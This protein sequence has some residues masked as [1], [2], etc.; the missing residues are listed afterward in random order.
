M[1]TDT[2]V[3][4]NKMPFMAAIPGLPLS[5]LAKRLVG[6]IRNGTGPKGVKGIVQALVY[7]DENGQPILVV[8]GPSFNVETGEVS[9]PEFVKETAREVVEGEKV[10]HN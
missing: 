9:I 3:V 6:D 1:D 2:M 10:Q 4:L 5:M 8:T 7:T